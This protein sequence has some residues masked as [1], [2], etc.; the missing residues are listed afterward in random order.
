LNF[1][2]PQLR[3]G[4]RTTAAYV[5]EDCSAYQGDVKNNPQTCAGAEDTADRFASC[6]ASSSEVLHALRPQV[7]YHLNKRNE[8]LEF[9]YQEAADQHARELDGLQQESHD[10]LAEAEVRLAEQAQEAAEQHHASIQV[11]AIINC[12]SCQLQENAF[13]K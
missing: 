13:S 10:K 9:D 7:I 5:K 1:D 3:D 12:T 4:W 6:S 2:Q 11:M 8:D